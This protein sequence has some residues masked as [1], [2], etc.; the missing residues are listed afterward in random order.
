MNIYPKIIRLGAGL[1]AD[2]RPARLSRPRSRSANAAACSASRLAMPRGSPRRRPPACRARRR[3]WT[4]P[5]RAFAQSRSALLPQIDATPNWTSHTLNS[6]S[7][8]FNFPAAPG[9]PPLLDPNGQIIGPVKF[10][11]FR[12]QRIAVA[13]RSQ[14][15]RTREGCA[16]QRDWRRTPT[17]QPPPNSRRRTPRTIYVRALRNDAA[18]QARLADSTVAADLLVIARD[19][20]TAG[21]GVG[22][23]VT[24]AQSQ[25]AAARAQLISAR[26]DRGRVAARSPARAQS[27]AR[28]AAGAHRLARLASA[29]RRDG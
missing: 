29:A 9:Q 23:D 16:G 15:T 4:K 7:F 5:R 24:R 13:V 1:H 21:V 26:N 17:S 6:A 2:R 22:L 18:L 10:W 11:D 20:L 25:L 27:A 8:G 19:Q 28:H 14:R 3:A 12:G